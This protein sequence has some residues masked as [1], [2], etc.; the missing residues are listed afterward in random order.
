MRRYVQVANGYASVRNCQEE[1]WSAVSDAG[2]RPRRTKNEKL[3][4]PV[5]AQRLT[6]L[7][8]I[9]DEVSL[10]PAFAQ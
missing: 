7:T 4:V 10:I 9:H 6:N 3:E 8:S 2:E 1:A 5:V